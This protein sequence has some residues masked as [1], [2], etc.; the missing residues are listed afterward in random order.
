MLLFRVTGIV[1]SSEHMRICQRRRARRANFSC[2]AAIFVF[3]FSLLAPISAHAEKVD[4]L[5]VQGYVNDFARVLDAATTQKL[6]ALSQQVDTKAGAQIAVVT[7][8]TLE[9]DTAQDF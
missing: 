6:T 1:Y 4:Q 3:V 9:G 7:I 2:R 5:S 8:H